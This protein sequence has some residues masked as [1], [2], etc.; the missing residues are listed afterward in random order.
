MNSESEF[1]K[2][3]LDACKTAHATPH[4][5]LCL[6]KLWVVNREERKLGS[7]VRWFK[8]EMEDEDWQELSN[9][10]AETFR[11]WDNYSPRLVLCK[12][13]SKNNV[14]FKFGTD[15]SQFSDS[16]KELI[17]DAYC[18]ALDELRRVN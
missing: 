5:S 12:E 15:P 17:F 1:V 4:R 8:R 14:S 2:S 7:H 9:F 16:T 11:T 13:T 6:L 18:H 3:W 10:I